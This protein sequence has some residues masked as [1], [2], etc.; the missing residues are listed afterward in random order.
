M[1][2]ADGIDTTIVL[3]YDIERMICRDIPIHAFTDSLSLFDVISRSTTTSEERP[4]IDITAEKESYKEGT[5]DTVGFIRTN[6]SPADAFTIV[7][8]CHAL[9]DILLHGKIEHPI[10][11]W[12][13]RAIRHTTETTELGVSGYFRPESYV[14]Q[15][16]KIGLTK[17]SV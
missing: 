10:E 1:A 9:E 6:F 16:Y 12:V 4:M 14:I 17:T 11:Q 5:I 2:Y 7:A 15:F 8:R 3:K 13:E